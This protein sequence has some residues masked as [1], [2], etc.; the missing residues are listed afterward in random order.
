[1]SGR[2]C[3]RFG[4]S[5]SLEVQRVIGSKMRKMRTVPKSKSKRSVGG[6]KNAKNAKYL[7]WHLSSASKV[8]GKVLS[9]FVRELQRVYVY[10]YRTMGQKTKGI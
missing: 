1:M 5:E 8:K 10:T 6:P 9:D 7:K 3:A 2:R 4:I